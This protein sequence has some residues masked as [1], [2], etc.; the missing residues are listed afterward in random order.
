MVIFCIGAIVALNS[1]STSRAG[2]KETTGV[3]LCRF[4]QETIDL[5][6]KI[7]RYKILQIRPIHKISRNVLRRNIT[8]LARYNEL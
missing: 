5:V 2:R 3:S 4:N 8:V 6:K 7:C 1:M